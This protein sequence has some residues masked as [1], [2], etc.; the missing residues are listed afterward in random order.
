MDSYS[1]NFRIKKRWVRTALIV[2]VTAMIVAPITA[3]AADRFTDVPDSNTFHDDISWLADAD[4]TKGCNPPANTQYCPS[5][6]VTR[7]Q[8]AAFLR[9]LA[10]NQVVDAGELDGQ[11]STAY[12]TRVEGENRNTEALT[13]NTVPLPGGTD[14]DLATIALSSGNGSHALVNYGFYGADSAATAGRLA[15]WVQLDDSDCT[16]TTL[17]Q[18]LDGSLT[19]QDYTANQVVGLAS[20]IVVPTAGSPDVTLCARSVVANAVVGESALNIL[21]A[22]T[23]SVTISTTGGSSSGLEDLLKP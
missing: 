12:V 10:E 14:I 17:A 9:R 23:G 16:L 2:L 4:V 18:I 22:N 15:A 1:V 21:Y 3:Y 13:V 11:D 8:M 5:D 19:I 6:N 20:T 7:G